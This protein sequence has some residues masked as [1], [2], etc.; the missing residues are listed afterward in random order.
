MS[1]TLRMWLLTIAFLSAL[2]AFALLASGMPEEGS[3]DH[4][5]R[6]TFV[7]PEEITP[8]SPAPLSFMATSEQGEPLGDVIITVEITLPEYGVKSLS[9][10]FYA[11]DGR[12]VITYNFQESGPHI[13]EAYLKDIEGVRISPTQSFIVNSKSAVALVEARLKGWLLLMGVL[14]LGLIVGEFSIARNVTG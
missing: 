9:G 4:G 6:V 12:T 1:P 13:V 2:L 10:D 8:G 14:V 3:L 5:A 11:I 7:P